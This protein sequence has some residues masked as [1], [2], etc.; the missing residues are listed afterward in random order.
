MRRRDFLI[1][2]GLA[3]FAAGGTYAAWR[4]GLLDFL[5][6]D[7][8][9]KHPAQV[10]RRPY[11]PEPGRML[12]VLG[13]GMMRLPI[14]AQDPNRIDEELAQK[15]VDYAVRHGVNYFDTAY[16]YMGGNSQKFTGKAL[17][18]YD[19]KSLFI[20]NKMPGMDPFVKTLADAKR[21]FEEQLKAC[22]TDYFDNYLCHNIWNI[23][24]F[25]SLY[26]QE[27]VLDYLRSEREKGRI[28]HL[29][30]SFHGDTTALA[31]FLK[32]PGWEFCQ[33][34]VNCMDWNETDGVN[35]AVAEKIGF[36]WGGVK[37]AGTHYRMAAAA[38]L[39]IVVMEP[40]RGGRLVS[41]NKAAVRRLQAAAP[42]QSVASWGM[43]FVA[44]LPAVQVA[45]SG[46]TRMSDVV[47]NVKTFTEGDYKP[48]AAAEKATLAAA[49]QDFLSQK[50]IACTGCR[51]CMPC[52]Y[53]VDIPGV[54]KI[55][56]DFAGE[57]LLGPAG[58][59][60]GAN[61]ADVRRFLV[62]YHNALAAR[63]DASHCIACGK[64]RP[65]CPQRIDI[66]AE[67]QKIEDLVVK[68]S[69]P[70]RRGNSDSSKSH[71]KG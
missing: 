69:R 13:F 32:Q 42:G 33:L 65:T 56:N 49:L 57:G 34:M 48:L 16:M 58:D 27:G 66:P 30:F 55:Y 2:G 23:D 68:L 45:L 46:M 52:N 6:A 43:R 21:V 35:S 64:C 60:V 41:L 40:L 50:T 5:A 20:V 4:A 17:E 70:S 38:G 22:R 31:Y 15:L 24:A 18:K 54:F 26:L 25:K 39:P 37:P 19:R 62:A 28:R 29:G 8:D 47:D 61:S 63:A 3:A 51:Y 44:S 36:S 12:S 67:M 53:G 9:G 10:I 1:G 11:G 59:G 14:L 71:L 7:A